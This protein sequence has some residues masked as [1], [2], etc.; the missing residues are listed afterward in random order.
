MPHRCRFTIP[1]ATALPV[2]L[3]GAVLL[4]TRVASSQ[5]RGSLQVTATV[6]QT[7]ADFDGLKAANQAAG[8]WAANGQQATND[9][10]TVAQVTITR[11][12]DAREEA[13]ADLV[14]SIDYLKN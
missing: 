3:A 5:A 14:V 7:Q 8:N 2:L 13:S 1:R 4:L 6:V 9:V 12:A 10:S 11:P